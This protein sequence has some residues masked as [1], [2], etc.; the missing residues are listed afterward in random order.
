MHIIDS[1]ENYRQ[2]QAIIYK[3]R[4]FKVA[5]PFVGSFSSR[6]PQLM[7]TTIL[8]VKKAPSQLTS[9]PSILSSFLCPY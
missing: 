7:S 1:N 3:S 9:F 4:A 6:G 5:A 2:A 8:K